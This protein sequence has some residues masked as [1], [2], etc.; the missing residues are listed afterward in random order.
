MSLEESLKDIKEKYYGFLY[1]YYR[2]EVYRETNWRNRLD[3]TT[4]WSI[5]VTAAIASFAFGNEDIPHIVFILNYFFV[6][7]FLYIEARR[8]RNYMLLRER[9]RLME[10]N[11]LAPI[12]IGHDL[13]IDLNN[14]W[15]SSLA[16]SL[17]SPKI[18]LSKTEAL[19]WRIRRNY[20]IILVFIAILWLVKVTTSPTKSESI[21]D[22]YKNARMWFI[23]G[24]IVF[25]GIIVSV[26][27]VIF[28]SLL[29]LNKTSHSDLP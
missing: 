24:E 11:L 9:T 6:L 29:S 1:H 10:K 18:E 16:D 20:A 23:P 2:A 17:N 25:W 19:A 14:E 28:L 21:F 5:V 7:S 8:F 26:F 3:T 22:V 12:L 4:N 27:T 13:D 15:R